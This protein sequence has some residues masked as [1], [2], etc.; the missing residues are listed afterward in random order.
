MFNSLFAVMALLA[1]PGAPAKPIAEEPPAWVEV[2]KDVHLLRGAFRPGSQ[3]D[4]NTVVFRGPSGWV[5]VDTGRHAAHTERIATF[6]RARGARITAVVNT[7]WHLDHVSGNPA[8]RAAFP[9][10]EV[11]ASD[12]I[13]EAMSGFLARYRRQLEEM[14]A[15]PGDAEGK[16]AF[17]AEMARIDAGASLFPDRP[18]TASGRRTLGG[19]VLELNLERAATQGDVWILDPTTHVLV[20]GDLVTLPAPFLDTACP[21]RWRA[22][23]ARMA[24]VDFARLVPGHGP[25]LSRADFAVYR[26]AFDTLLACGASTRPPGEC[27]SGWITDAGALIPE[28]ER[29]FA[30]SMAEYYV[31]AHLRGD[32]ARAAELCR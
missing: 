12:A 5:V 2:A 3:P 1:A 30:R 18:V 7:H 26:R 17:Q 9:G 16:R 21:A 25:D 32:P 23:L 22:A 10:L 19:R 6:A 31:E 29:D 27:V 8:L 11:H 20:A 13:R 14:V 24:K 15:R 28:A 4:A